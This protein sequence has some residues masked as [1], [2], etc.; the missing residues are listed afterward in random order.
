MIRQPS[1]IAYSFDL[2]VVGFCTSQPDDDLFARP[3]KPAGIS[4]EFLSA[5][6]MNKDELRQALDAASLSDLA[7]DLDGER[8]DA[9]DH[10][11]DQFRSIDAVVRLPK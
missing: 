3:G 11:I 6:F 8:R 1:S 7:S 9:V 2:S 10:V 4:S 5:R